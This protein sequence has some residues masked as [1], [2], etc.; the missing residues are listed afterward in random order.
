MHSA[1]C[2]NGIQIWLNKCF[3]AVRKACLEQTTNSSAPF[4]R[5][6]SAYSREIIATDSGMRINYTERRGLC[7]EML[8]AAGQ[9]DML[10]HIR[11]VSRVECMSVVHMESV[12][13]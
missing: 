6:L 9:N 10:E 1:S 11:K 8:K 2:L 5:P 3:D 13:L 4:T 12:L 7:F